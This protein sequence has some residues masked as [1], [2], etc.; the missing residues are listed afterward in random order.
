MAFA[1]GKRQTGKPAESRYERAKTWMQ[2]HGPDFMRSALARRTADPQVLSIIGMRG[3][4]SS[5]AAARNTHTPE[6]VLRFLAEPP[7][8]FA[9]RIDKNRIAE[10]LAQNTSTPPD[11][12]VIFIEQAEFKV[13]FMALLNRSCPPET[14][15]K[16]I[17]SCQIEKE[18]PMKHIRG[19]Y[20]GRRLPRKQ[21]DNGL[22]DEQLN[23]RDEIDTEQPKRYI[24]NKYFKGVVVAIIA[25]EGPERKAILEGMKLHDAELAAE[26]ESAVHRTDP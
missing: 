13:K 12:F 9:D 1:D 8:W 23:G 3:H 5:E 6:D 17:A 25:R 18:H 24:H 11:S 20:E 10:A 15:A 7:E 14:A 26:L 21:D 2:F 22:S 16:I 19:R 4:R